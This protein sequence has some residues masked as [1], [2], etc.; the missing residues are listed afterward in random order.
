MPKISTII[1]NGKMS[2]IQ[3]NIKA[4]PKALIF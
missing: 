1:N 4:K 2:N 3:K